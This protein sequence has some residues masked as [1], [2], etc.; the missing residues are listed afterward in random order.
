MQ[1]L[2]I[3]YE[4]AI[5]LIQQLSVVDNDGKAVS[6]YPLHDEQIDIIASLWTGISTLILKPRQIG[7]STAVCAYLFLMLLLSAEPIHIVILSHKQ[8]ASKELL[9]KAK[10]MYESLPAPMKR[11][12]PAKITASEIRMKR[13]GARITAKGANDK[14]GIRSFS[15]Q[16]LWLSEFA[17]MENPEELLATAIPAVNKGQLIIEST[18]NYFEDAFHR[19]I[20]SSLDGHTGYEFLFFPWTKHAKYRSDAPIDFELNED[21]K[22]KGLTADQAH[23]YRQKV[24]TLGAAKMI[25]DYPLTIEEAYAQLDGAFLSDEVLR[26]LVKHE[27]TPGKI[28][29]YT[30]PTADTRYVIGADPAFGTG[31]DSSSVH[32]I[33]CK[34]LNVVA[35]FRS[36]TVPITKFAHIIGQLSVEYGIGSPTGKAL[37]N[38]EANSEGILCYDRL[39]Q[40]NIPVHLIDGKPWKTHTGNKATILEAVRSAIES[41][42]MKEID[43]FTYKEL[44]SVKIDNYGRLEIPKRLGSHADGIMSLGLAL[45]IAN[46]VIIPKKIDPN[47]QLLNE[48]FGNRRRRR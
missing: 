47:Q 20:N 27:D 18:A 30:K 24:A 11:M 1:R 28:N 2:S 45:I 33:D 32:V 31:N 23:W 26:Y 15:C 5:E 14:G 7:C 3:S 44:R 10:H 22:A 12:F 42:A 17:F 25:R 9:D 21:E 46:Q 39:C 13:T 43:T 41:K 40:Q 4:K 8:I 38:I 16:Y 36:N 48:I 19:L 29:F 34:T 35:S 37:V 6:L